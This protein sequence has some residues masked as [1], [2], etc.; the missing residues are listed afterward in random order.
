MYSR[1]MPPEVLSEIFIQC[2]DFT[3]WSDRE[4]PMLCFPDDAPHLLTQVCRSWRT[5]AM[6]TPRLWSTLSL[7]DVP[8]TSEQ[9]EC[10]YAQV[11]VWL[12]LSRALPLSFTLRMDDEDEDELH[13]YV[14]LL[15]TEIH[16]WK[17]AR[18]EVSRNSV[19]RFP[20]F[21]P[22]STP[23]LEEFCLNYIADTEGEGVPTLMTALAS[24]PRLYE[25]ELHHNETYHW[26]LPWASL[27]TLDIFDYTS[28]FKTES[29]ARF[30]E[31]LG[32]CTSLESLSFGI[33]TST[34]GPLLPPTSRVVLPR[35]DSF[36]VPNSHVRTIVSLM[37]TLV[38]PRLDTL[39][40]ERSSFGLKFSRAVVGESI[41]IFLAGSGAVLEDLQLSGVRILPSDLVRC[42]AL[43]PALKHLNVWQEELLDARVF[44]ALTLDFDHSGRLRSGTNP[45]LRTI[46]ILPTYESVNEDIDIMNIV[47]V[48]PSSLRRLDRSA[49]DD[50]HAP[51]NR[52]TF[53]G[54][55]VPKENSLSATQMHEW[56]ANFGSSGF[57]AA[58][59]RMVTSRWAL[60]PKANASRLE[61]L[62][63]VHFDLHILER[64]MP[65]QF[66]KVVK[67]W[68][69]GLKLTVW[70]SRRR[71]EY[72]REATGSV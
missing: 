62:M 66:R 3:A 57:S 45:R 41:R 16:R 19:H 10:L 14:S 36:K 63:L 50:S 42:L 9:C 58:F 49:D 71:E 60:P 46:T 47:P 21:E 69:E 17:V 18:F 32:T 2:L 55:P 52:I 23:L 37:H 59:A 26:A 53:T 61:A 28:E 70:C 44:A 68:M 24:A 35:L 64:A 40:L 29:L 8:I 22:G 12:S 5:V 30:C 56:F 38:A 43:L 67:C 65:E 1:H 11:R 31:M 54:P 4:E 33:S 27:T 25:I 13:R 51:S 34:S 15:Q 48:P 7:P 72:W 39:S 20:V 6:S